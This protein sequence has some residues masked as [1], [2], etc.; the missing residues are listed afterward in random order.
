MLLHIQ[1]QNHLDFLP[2]QML[3][4]QLRFWDQVMNDTLYC[5]I[6][7]EDSVY[8]M[9]LFLLYKLFHTATQEQQGSSSQALR[10]MRDC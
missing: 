10:R 5:K 2:R 6:C 8:E 1:Q 3:M 9:C 7:S 4:L